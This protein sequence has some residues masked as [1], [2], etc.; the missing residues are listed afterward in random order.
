L[1]DVSRINA[2]HLQL[3]AAPVEPAHVVQL[4]IDSVKPVSDAK[5]VRIAATVGD[6]APILGDLGRLHQVLCNLLTNS[7][8]FSPDGGVVEIAVALAPPNVV[9][10]VRDHGEGID[11][12]FMPHLFEPFRQADAGSARSRGGLGLGL[13]ITKRLVELHRGTIEAH[14]DGEGRG[15]TF[16]VRLPSAS[17]R[18][19]ATD[20]PALSPDANPSAA[21]ELDGL[22]VLLIE[23]EP[24]TRE[25][26]LNLFDVCGAN[27]CGMSSAADAMAQFH[28]DRPDII[29]SDVGLPGEDGLTFL[30]KLRHLPGGDV[31][32]VALTA[33]VRPEDREVAL[34]AG[35]DAHV[36]KPIEPEEFLHIV[37][38]VLRDRRAREHAPA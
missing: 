23:D 19:A 1:L 36:A 11:P 15:A 14:S 8:K 2:G 38:Q 6:N 4:A 9:I 20:A 7:V 5:G 12:E 35:F 18:D 21:G 26:L 33:F 31:P 28:R 24:D 13:T 34:A 29:V 17:R 25:L 37:T 16:I 3:N 22:H 30:R 27:A 10:T 32:A